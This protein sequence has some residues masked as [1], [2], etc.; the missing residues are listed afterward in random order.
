M[1][2]INKVLVKS[3]VA[4]AMLT[5]ALEKMND[6]NITTDKIAEEYANKIIEELK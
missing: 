5:F 2:E 4:Q 3:Y 6:I 1:N